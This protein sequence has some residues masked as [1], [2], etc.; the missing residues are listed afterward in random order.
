MFSFRKRD[1]C[2]NHESGKADTGRLCLLSQDYTQRRAEAASSRGTAPRGRPVAE[3]GDSG[4]ELTSPFP[5]AH[6]D[7]GAPPRQGLLN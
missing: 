7:S 2:T 5:E 3:Q 1:N 4:T 6:P